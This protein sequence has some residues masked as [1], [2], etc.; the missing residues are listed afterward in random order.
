M[1]RTDYG[2]L[3]QSQVR[4]EVYMNYTS[5]ILYL[6]TVALTVLANRGNG[7]RTHFAVQ[8]YLTMVIMLCTLGATGALPA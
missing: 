2:T 3:V 4:Y 1:E 5:F 7:N 6:V 8:L